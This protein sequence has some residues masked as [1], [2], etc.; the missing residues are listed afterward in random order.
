MRIRCPSW[1]QRGIWFP[2]TGKS[3]PVRDLRTGFSGIGIG[4][5]GSDL[6]IGLSGTG[7]GT[8]WP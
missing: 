1:V 8:P 7:N 2:G 5:P 6:R 4:T 3:T